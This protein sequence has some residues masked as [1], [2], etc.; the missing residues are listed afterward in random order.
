MIGLARGQL[1]VC[2]NYLY[3]GTWNKTHHNLKNADIPPSNYL[4]WNT[5]N[6]WKR[7]GLYP[8]AGSILY[9]HWVNDSC[10]LCRCDYQIRSLK[11]FCLCSKQAKVSFSTN[12][13]C[14]IKKIRTLIFFRLQCLSWECLPASEY[15]IASLL[16]SP[17][18]Q[19]S[20]TSGFQL[21]W[22]TLRQRHVLK[23]MVYT[24]TIDLISISRSRNILPF[25]E[26]NRQ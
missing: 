25:K 1:Q 12:F 23:T 10:L 24:D 14:K 15:I 5:K 13:L 17:E 2:K 20:N 16:G 21:Y 3:L 4:V 22:V 19:N 7:L 9:Q 11:L 8:Y 18:Q 26:K 6:G